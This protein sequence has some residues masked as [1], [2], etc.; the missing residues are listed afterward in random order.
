MVTRLK[1]RLDVGN[2]SF[3]QIFLLHDQNAA[4]IRTACTS[5]RGLNLTLVKERYDTDHRTVDVFNQFSN[6]IR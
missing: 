4:K 1:I 6:K 5:T 3:F 2:Y